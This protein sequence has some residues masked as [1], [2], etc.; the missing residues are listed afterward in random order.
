MLTRGKKDALI[1]IPVAVGTGILLGLYYD[2]GKW[3]IEK[4]LCPV[5]AAGYSF[6]NG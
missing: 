5:F 1:A 4:V 2:G 6:W 3:F